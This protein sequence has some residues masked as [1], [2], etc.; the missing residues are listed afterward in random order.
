LF[1]VFSIIVI[2]NFVWKIPDWIDWLVAM[3]TFFYLLLAIKRFYGKDI[4]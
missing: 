3:S 2:V 1:T 4:F